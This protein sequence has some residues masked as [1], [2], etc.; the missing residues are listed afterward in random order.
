[1]IDTKLLIENK[2]ENFKFQSFGWK[3]KFIEHGKVEELE[4]LYELDAQS[5]VNKVKELF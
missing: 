1:M 5:I 4:V 2:V 3:D